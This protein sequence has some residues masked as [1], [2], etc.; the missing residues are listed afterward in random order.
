VLRAL[1]S[2]NRKNSPCWRACPPFFLSAIFVAEWR[3]RNETSALGCQ[4]LTSSVP[5]CWERNANQSLSVTPTKPFMLRPRAF[6]YL[7][8][9]CNPDP[10]VFYFIHN[11][12]EAALCALLACGQTAIAPYRQLRAQD[13]PEPPQ[14]DEA[15]PRISK[16]LRIEPTN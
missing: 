11:L 16:G 14:P 2:L 6:H 10:A 7:C 4:K 13:C 8:Q 1:S 3:A 15:H 9:M 12:S 5:W